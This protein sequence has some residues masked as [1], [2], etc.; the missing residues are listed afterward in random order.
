MLDEQGC[1]GGGGG[2]GG[3]GGTAPGEA[4]DPS[5]AAAPAGEGGDAGAPWWTALPPDGLLQAVLLQALS[6]KRHLPPSLLPVLPAALLG[7]VMAGAC[8]AGLRC[9]VKRTSWK[10]FGAFLAAMRATGLIEVDAEGRLAGWDE[11]HPLFVAHHG[12]PARVEA[13]AAGRSGG[14]VG[15]GS[16]GGGGGGGGAA[17]GEPPAP[18]APA[19]AA[20]APPTAA[21]YLRPTPAMGAVVT[22]VLLARL[23]PW[24]AAARGAVDAGGARAPLPQLSL[25]GVLLV[26]RKRRGG[27]AAARDLANRLLPLGAAVTSRALVQLGV[28]AAPSAA[29]VGEVEEEE[30]EEEEEEGLVEGEGGG[31]KGEGGDGEGGAGLEAAVGDPPEG[32]EA[33]GTV[34]L[35]LLL[36]LLP[37]LNSSTVVLLLTLAEAS[38]CVR[39]YTSLRGL[40]NGREQYLDGALAGALAGGG[41]GAA[42]AP[43]RARHAPLPPLLP[44]PPA[45]LPLALAP[46]VAAAAPSLPRADVNALFSSKARPWWALHFPPRGEVVAREGAL[47]LVRVGKKVL[48]GGKRHLTYVVGLEAYRLAPKW[49]AMELAKRLAAA[50]TLQPAAPLGARLDGTAGEGGAPAGGAAVAVVAQGEEVE[51]V[52][53]WLV[54]TLGLPRAAVAGS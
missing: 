7:S 16:G 41:K 33:P 13:G 36:A 30:E 21:T 40:G 37:D 25:P 54:G 6:R 12:W 17:A 39:E 18:A 8:P 45:A 2:G 1:G 26:R 23:L 19:A 49:V 46:H 47:P 42:A 11:A 4:G 3:S 20:W 28:T 50:T 53:E 29:E 38:E 34:P 51:R 10:K 52:A 24:W 27:G 15:E 22:T 43:P 5:G 14:G 35:A 48:Q 31:E 9:D 32:V 44:L